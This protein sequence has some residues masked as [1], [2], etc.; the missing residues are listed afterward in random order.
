M[1]ESQ[2][3]D[4]C[5]QDQVILLLFVRQYQCCRPLPAIMRRMEEL[6]HYIIWC[7]NNNIDSSNNGTTTTAFNRINNNNTSR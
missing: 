2:E 1:W 7:S 5:R 3:V 6:T 4:Y